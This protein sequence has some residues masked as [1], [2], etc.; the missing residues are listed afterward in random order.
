MEGARRNLIDDRMELTGMKWSLQG[1]EAMFRL[2]SVDINGDWEDFWMFHRK[3]ERGR[4]IIQPYICVFL[5]E[6]Y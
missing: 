3:N 6:P 5:Q 4:R 1:A 2:R